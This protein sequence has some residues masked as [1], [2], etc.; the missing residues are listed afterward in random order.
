[1]TKDEKVMPMAKGM[2]MPDGAK[3]ANTAIVQFEEAQIGGFSPP[4][5][6][7]HSS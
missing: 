3:V 1:M 6:W 5:F 2:T 4:P 7:Q